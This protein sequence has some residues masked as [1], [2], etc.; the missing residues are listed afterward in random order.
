MPSLT[1]HGKKRIAER[2]R[3]YDAAARRNAQKALNR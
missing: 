2:I 1:K 3:A